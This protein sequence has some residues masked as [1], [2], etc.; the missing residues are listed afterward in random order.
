MKRGNLLS[1]F[2]SAV[3]VL[4]S[5]TISS[6]FGAEYRSDFTISGNVEQTHPLENDL[7]IRNYRAGTYDTNLITITVPAAG[8]VTLDP[9]D[10]DFYTAVAGATRWMAYDNQ[11][12]PNAS[13][14]ARGGTVFNGPVTYTLDRAG[15]VFIYIVNNNTN[16]QS[17]TL[18]AGKAFIKFSPTNPDT[19]TPVDPT[20]NVCKA[21]A[22]K[23]IGIDDG[24]LYSPIT[25]TLDGITKYSNGKYSGFYGMIE[26]ESAG[27]V[28]VVTNGSCKA[29]I[30]ISSPS[31]TDCEA[32]A[33]TS[34]TVSEDQKFYIRVSPADNAQNGVSK[35]CEVK[36][37]FV[38]VDSDK[39]TCRSFDTATLGWVG[40]TLNNQTTYTAN[41]VVRYGD[42]R[43]TGFWG[44][45]NITS[46]G[47]VTAENCEDG[48]ANISIDTS[49]RETTCIASNQKSQS[50]TAGSTVYV[51]ISPNEDAQNNYVKNPKCTVKFTPKDG[52]GPG[53]GGGS[54]GD[55]D[56]N[57][58]VITP[59][60]ENPGE[61][62]NDL[63][64]NDIPNSGK[65]F[66]DFT[67][68]S[69]YLK[70]KTEKFFG[71]YGS[72]VYG[73][74]VVTGNS[75]LSHNNFGSGSMTDSTASYKTFGGLNLN[76]SSETL[77]I[78]KGLTKNDI[79]YVRLYWQGHIF[80][81]SITNGKNASKGWKNVEL[82]INNKSV[83]SVTADKKSGQ[84]TRTG[85]CD[86]YIVG[87][88]GQTNTVKYRMSY[89]C[90]EDITELVK[91][92]LD[93]D[94]IDGLTFSVGNIKTTA[95][96][97]E[98]GVSMNNGEA[99]YDGG[100]VL[101]PYGGWGIVLVYN[102]TTADQEALAEAIDNNE[103]SGISNGSEYIK[104]YFKPKSVSIYGH[105]TVISPW[106]YF[107]PMEVKSS[108]E[109]F[110]TPKSGKVQAK[111][112]F[113]GLGA[114]KPLSSGEYFKIQDQKNDNSGATFALL[115]NRENTIINEQK[116]IS[117]IFNSTKTILKPGTYE[118][119]SLSN[120]T[121]GFDLDEFDISDLMK[122]EQDHLEF[123]LGGS[124]RC[125]SYTNPSG[126]T[127]PENGLCNTNGYYA[128]QDFI[129]M[130]AISVDIYVPNICYM[131]DIYDTSGW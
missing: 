72:Y 107:T 73:D 66:K 131:A 4:L 128:N 32:K 43:Y 87:N 68:I 28:N 104:T 111:L 92:N 27:T 126:T 84:A 109:G 114:D 86:G 127:D 63:S 39:P 62:N 5:F 37:N 106:R 90:T 124:M 108:V 98:G 77:R 14:V 129:S 89:A 52:T 61:P 31:A 42:G 12:N 118:L 8:T 46:D 51:H 121:H 17:A 119:E 93:D 25:Y 82:K 35:E 123:A 76:G 103:I 45:I 91:E 59:P 110:F 105:Y 75:V 9:N 58:I 40:N 33:I 1:R 85:R 41:G 125:G 96:K 15:T 60:V 97:D 7:I 29:S 80:N 74:Y 130:I 44:A 100:T 10:N 79:A 122:N 6:A 67:G 70:Q 50:V 48:P 34:R 16:N 120:N 38:P 71:G 26:A 55:D 95:A 101:G 78:P 22:D 102:K 47:T 49:A 113:L 3:L 23:N 81:S 94:F 53:G 65:F 115:S 112:S 56:D 21:V 69:D 36:V 117:S 11:A 57:P 13:T 99:D 20:N 64:D 88:S 83:V 24:V 19:P 2:L 116:G 54:T 18:K 30:D